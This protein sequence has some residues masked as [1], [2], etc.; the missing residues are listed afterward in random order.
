[1]TLILG[2]AIALAAAVGA[3]ARR[4]NRV[5]LSPDTVTAK[6]VTVRVPIGWKIRPA[7]ND[8]G[9]VATATEDDASDDDEGRTVT[10]RVERL[11]TPV[12]PMQ[13]L[14]THFEFPIADLREHRSGDEPI[15]A[16]PMAGQTGLMMT[17]E[18]GS[19]RRRTPTRKQIVAAVILPSQ[20]GVIVRL[21]GAGEA[22]RYDEAVVRQ[23]AGAITMANE[24]A[25]GQPGEV[26]TLVDGIRFNA[27]RG[28]A[29]VQ[30]ADANRTD[31]KLWPVETPAKKLEEVE[32]RWAL[33]ET[34]GCLCPDF[35]ASNLK[36]AE[37]AETT[38]E[39]L[40][41]ARDSR[42][43]DAVVTSVGNRTWRAESARAADGAA[44]GIFSGRAYLM[45][46][47]SGRALLSVFRGGFGQHDF[48]PAWKEIAASVTFLK[49]TD[50]AGL[51]DVGAVEAARLRREGYEKLLAD[52]DV[53]WWLWTSQ[54]AH[55]GWSSLD[56]PVTGLV[57]KQ[58]SRVR[59]SNGARVNRLTHDF[60]YHDKGPQ[61]KSTITQI[62][63]DG[64][65][66]SRLRTMQTT[67]LE[68]GQLSLSFKPTA[69]AAS[70]QQ[71]KVPAPPQFVPGALLPLVLGQL[72]R[73]PMVLLTDTFP[74]RDGVGAPQLLAVIIR[75]GENSTRVAEGDDKPMRCVTVQV[76]GTGT[77]SRWYFRKTGELES[78]DWPGGV[79]QVASDQ[80][81]VRNNF[82]KD[83][84]LAP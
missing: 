23:I 72:S 25:I 47:P 55:V 18:H 68:N 22:D 41:L 3:S 45:T 44:A 54:D 15:V 33:I 48:D 61:Y 81:V 74:T 76:N 30:A 62:V 26:V 19:R 20:R 42:W 39:T 40:L 84:L 17:V 28:F 67:T 8:P 29:P 49:A 63:N 83:D 13:F 4:A 80:N 82:P 59:L 79:Q 16:L 38:L 2:A 56:F 21:Q 53:E 27:P 14:I 10:I 69:T 58:E 31:R 66:E 6:D 34:L 36:E 24:P 71:W 1:M 73:E 70:V 11:L 64:D 60:S 37:Q 77:T 9:L 35:D 5:E 46:D 50:V 57:G 43:R 75:P 12:S 65:S 78:V 51:Q 52:R 7:L 32:G